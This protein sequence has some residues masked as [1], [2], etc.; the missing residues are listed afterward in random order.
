M[1]SLG[2]MFVVGISLGS[3]PTTGVAL[4]LQ[5][6]AVDVG[7][8]ID[9]GQRYIY[10]TASEY[11]ELNLEEENLPSIFMEDQIMIPVAL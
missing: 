6:I 8:E 10:Q 5:V 11:L 9:L 2:A 1:V 4:A 7:E 3:R